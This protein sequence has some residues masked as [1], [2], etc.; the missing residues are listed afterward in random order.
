MP[1]T[2]QN[3]LSELA[4]FMEAGEHTKFQ[5]LQSWQEYLFT[6]NVKR[7]IKTLI[8]SLGAAANKQLK[9]YCKDIASG[10]SDFNRL[11]AYKYLNNILSFYLEELKI[12]ENMLDEYEAYLA[13]GN[14]LD[15]IW[16]T[17]RPQSKL[18][19]HRW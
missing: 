13:A 7:A 6:R 5:L 3:I 17:K 15:F 10:N 16:S 8:K 2:E 9:S 14:W 18:W 1:M 19:D 12:T 4:A 11:L